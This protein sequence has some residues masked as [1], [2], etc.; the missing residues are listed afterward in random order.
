M[1]TKAR[2]QVAPRITSVRF[3]RYK[4]LRQFSVSLKQFNVLVGANNAGKSTILGAFRIL[5]EGIRRAESRKAELVSNGKQD[6]WGYRVDLADL[7]VSTENVF[8]DYDDSEPAEI[9]FRISNGNQISLVFPEVGVC[10][11]VPNSLNAAVR[12]PSEFVREFPIKI[13]FVPTLGPVEHREPLYQREAA[14]LALST[15]GASRNF[16]NIWHHYPDDFVR[17]RDMI[18]AT[19]PGMDIEQ[20]VVQRTEKGA[21]LAMFCPESRYPREIFWAGFGFQVWCQML[22]F[23]LRSRDAAVLVVDEP[24]IYLHSDLQRQL[25]TILRTL[26]PDIVIATHSTEMIS[27][28]APEE[29]LLVRKGSASAKRLERPQQ[30]QAVFSALGSNANPILTQLARTRRVVF[31]EGHDFG[32]LSA[33]SKKLGLSQVSNRSEFAVI[34][35]KGFDPNKA[36]DLLKGFELALG[37]KPRCAVIFDRDYRS[38][39]EV[40]ETVA[41]IKSFAD[42]A[43]IHERKE[44]EN[45]ALSPNALAVAVENSLQDRELRTGKPRR[46]GH[47]SS[48]LLELVV[49]QMKHKVQAQYLAKRLQFERS[50]SPGLDPA[51]VSESSMRE[52]DRAWSTPEGRLNVVPGK[53]VISGLNEQLQDEY[54]VHITAQ[55]IVEKMQPEE[56][57]ADLQALL[58]TLDMFRRSVTDE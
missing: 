55:A 21:T 46:L 38:D 24:D 36:R 47:T 22:T 4:A 14:R 56:I 40:A 43:H 2:R 31:V 45:Y 35:V 27:E 20:P 23:L 7:P 5:A 54:D 16:R 3:I 42:V 12:S 6:V 18:Q 30:L 8:S 33:F 29:L 49:N 28:A 11:L 50:K 53:E 44:L 15:Q 10:I 37:Y 17:F 19:W 48:Q 9:T 34:P 32:L 51:T 13:A 57:A 52:F 58:R 25:L 39:A 41:K 1:A 26:G